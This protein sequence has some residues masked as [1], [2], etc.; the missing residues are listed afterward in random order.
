MAPVTLDPGVVQGIRRAVTPRFNRYTK[1]HYGI[2]GRRFLARLSAGEAGGKSVKHA[3]TSSAGARGPFQFIPSTRAAYKARYGIDPWRSNTEAAKAAII[4]IMGTGLKGYNPGMPT[5]SK[6]ILGQRIS[7]QSRRALKGGPTGGKYL[8]KVTG[9]RSPSLRGKPAHFNKKAFLL[10]Y[11]RDERKGKSLAG[12]YL[13]AR[14]TGEYDVASTLKNLPGKVKKE[15][16][17][18]ED[19]GVPGKVG[20]LVGNPL[21]R[22][23]VKT[24]KQTLN[25][26][27]QVAGVFGHPIRLGTGT[28]HSRLTVN[29][30][31]SDHWGGHALDLP[32]SGRR[33]ILM[34]QAALI[35]AGMSPKRARKIRGG[36]FN[37]NG[38]QIIFNTQEGG[39]HTD[40]LHI[41]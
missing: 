15:R 14:Q 25:F 3:G 26:A 17:F 31:V 28:Q 39:D 6:Y 10:D 30:N 36:L 2:S 18:I 41:H 13:H 1:K 21:D 7:K 9:V 38:H 16:V 34:G 4:H 24:S 32:A 35:A 33:L 11:L 27:R 8:T 37:I 29:G 40:H 5:Y 23:G 20:K 22:P 19:G 12:S